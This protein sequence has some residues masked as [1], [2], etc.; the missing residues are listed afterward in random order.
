MSLF[1][2]LFLYVIDADAFETDLLTDLFCLLAGS[3]VVLIALLIS[4]DSFLAISFNKFF[5][6]DL[7]ITLFIQA[8]KDFFTNFP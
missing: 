5:G 2:S 3:T 6:V 1:S 8:A 4:L 7:Q